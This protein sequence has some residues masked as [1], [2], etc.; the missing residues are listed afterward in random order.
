MKTD[1]LHAGAEFLVLNAFDDNDE[2]ADISK[3]TG[4]SDWQLVVIYRGRHCPLCT[5]F[6]NALAGYRQRLLDIGIDIAAASADSR[7]Q[8]DEHRERL[9]VNF[10]LYYGL[11][12][13]QMQDLGL[14]ISVPRS[15]QETDHNFAEPGLFVINS[16]GKVQVVD[17]SNNPFSRPDLE[18]FV[19]GLEWIRS[20]EN[21]YPIRGTYQ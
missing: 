15:E 19:S 8:L 5:K 21:N 20:P 6:L 1:K 12:L 3:P 16:D 7:E 18:V 11:T 14:Y 2:L 9:D 13:E 17:L 4:D 10:P